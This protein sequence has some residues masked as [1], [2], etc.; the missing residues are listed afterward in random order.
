MKVK[1]LKARAAVDFLEGEIVSLGEARK[2]AT[3]RGSGVVANA[4]LKD[5][6]GEVKLT[7]WNEQATQ[8]SEGD[9]VK[10][11]NGWCGEWKGELQVSTGKKGIL[12]KV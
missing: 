3:E 10:L 4:A 9:A 7:L 11:E 1:D 2:F 6:T 8:F 12:S 5:E